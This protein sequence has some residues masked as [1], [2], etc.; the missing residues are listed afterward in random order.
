MR[1]N[2]TFVDEVNSCHYNKGKLMNVSGVPV[3][4]ELSGM[5]SSSLNIRIDKRVP[6][7]Y[8]LQ[9]IIHE[10]AEQYLS[11]YSD[12][13]SVIGECHKQSIEIEKQLVGK[14]RFNEVHKWL[15]Q[16][17]EENQKEELIEPTAG[18]L[19]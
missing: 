4:S 16:F 8:V 7:D 6:K 15:K 13:E 11:L 14:E 1:I 18:E 12:D 19:K 2:I 17:C 9:A 5:P 3:V 10:L